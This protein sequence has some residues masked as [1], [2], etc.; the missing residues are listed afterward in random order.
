MW[1]AILADT[2]LPEDM[3][4]LHTMISYLSLHDSLS[5]PRRPLPSEL[6]V[7]RMC[8]LLNGGAR[9]HISHF[10]ISQRWAHRSLKH[11]FKTPCHM[12][13]AQYGLV[14][15]WMDL[16]AHICVWLLIIWRVFLYK[17]QIYARAL[18]SARIGYIIRCSRTCYDLKL[19]KTNS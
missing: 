19:R 11:S 3:V 10:P 13:T 8:C 17:I 7:N 5:V 15:S 18:R 12:W 6:L 9:D 4:L 14:A 2:L 16:S 1:P